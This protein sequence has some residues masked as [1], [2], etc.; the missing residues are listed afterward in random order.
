MDRAGPGKVA[1]P[2]G[3]SSLI[4]S[5]KNNNNN[6]NNNNEGG[7]GGGD[8]YDNDNNDDDDCATNSVACAAI[9][10]RGR[11]LTRGA[12]HFAGRFTPL[13]ILI[14]TSSDPRGVIYARRRRLA[15]AWSGRTRTRVYRDLTPTKKDDASTRVVIITRGQANSDRVMARRALDAAVLLVVV[16]ATCCTAMKLDLESFLR[17]RQQY[18]PSH[19]RAEDGNHCPPDT[20]FPCKTTAKCIPMKYLCDDNVD[21]KDGYDEDPDVCTAAHR[22]AVDQIA[23]FLVEKQSWI[24]PA[25]FDN[26]KI[27]TVAHALAVSQTLDDFQK[28]IELPDKQTKS[29]RL[30]LEAVRDS[31]EEILEEFGMPSSDWGEVDYVFSKLIKSGFL[32]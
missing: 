1:L 29:L 16:L 4:K 12:A 22:P 14:D 19:K 10:I 28:R 25:F 27:R 24:M 5:T 18:G 32:G 9:D 15:A 8:C 23:Q 21:C 31:Q 13:V 2:Y 6:N 17:H 26:K 3:T 11:L 20:P 30:A 7:G